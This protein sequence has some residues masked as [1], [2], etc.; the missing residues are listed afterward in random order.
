MAWGEYGE[1]I[2]EY[3]QGIAA[4]PKYR[5]GYR[6]LIVEALSANDRRAEAEAVNE[7]ILKDYPNNTDALAR[8]AGMLL[9]RGDIDRAIVQLESMLRQSPNHD[10]LRYN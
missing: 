6:K 8:R 1:G 10:L 4:F 5:A 7:S 9:E 2:R 3:E